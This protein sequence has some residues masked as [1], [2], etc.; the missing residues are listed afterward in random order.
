MYYCYYEGCNYRFHNNSGTISTEN[1]PDYQYCSWSITVGEGFVVSLN[2]ISINIPSCSDGNYINFYDGLDDTAPLIKS[3]CN[4]TSDTGWI[5]TSGNKLFIALKSG[6]SRDVNFNAIY[7]ATTDS[8]PSEEVGSPEAYGVFKWPKTSVGSRSTLA[9]PYNNESSA[10]RECLYAPET[11]VWG[12]IVLNECNYREKRSK[13][14]FLL[15]QK[16]VTSNNVAKIAK[17]MKNLSIANPKMSLHPGDINNIATVLEKIVGVKDKA[18]EILDDFATT[19]DNLLDASEENIIESQSSSRVV[20]ALNNFAETLVIG[21]E[22]KLQKE[23]KNFAMKLKTVETQNF[24]GLE[25]GGVDMKPGE[26][27]LIIPKTIF[28]ESAVTDNSGNQTAIFV[29]YKETKFFRVSSDDTTRKLGRLNSLVLA[30]SIKGLSVKNLRK[31]VKIA[32]KSISR[33]DANSTL[34]S[35][36]NFDLGNWSQD[37]CRF[38]QVLDDGRMLCTCDH[39]TNFAMLMDCNPTTANNRVLSVVSYVGCALSLVGLA[40]TIIMILALKELRNKIP[41]Q[42]L[43]NFCISLSLTLIVFMA[44]VERSKT[45]SLVGC[46]T[47]AIALHY[48]MLAAFA[49]MA[50]EAYNMYLAFVK[51][52]PNSTSSKFILKC[53]L[54]AWGTPAVIVS[55]TMAAALDKYGDETYCRLQGIPFIVALLTPVAFILVGNTITFYFIL[56]SLLKSGKDVTSDLKRRGFQQTRQGIAIMV[57]LGLTWIFGV[58][59]I[60]DAK[61][62][63]QYLFCIFNTL[64][65]LFVFILFCILPDGTRRQIKKFIRAKTTIARRRMQPQPQ[66]PQRENPGVNNMALSTTDLTNTATPVRSTSKSSWSSKNVARYNESKFESVTVEVKVNKIVQTSG[67]SCSKLG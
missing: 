52:F 17:Q 24:N 53:C 47:A 33:G 36:W 30:G 16:N 63:F 39:F 57:L 12:S 4:E 43:L 20:K 31:P 27:S 26:S 14:I 34:C 6:N 67:A 42:I 9:C 54:F 38:E 13:D 18:N 2:S 5:L 21:P 49:W 37:G 64:Q 22:G 61:L 11:S 23:T 50:V 25:Y 60:D 65:G 56:R 8:C 51:V 40:S 3:L 45:S 41:S 48:F 66:N 32:F 29:L 7:Y 10:S 58:L 46:M 44:A 15:V 62:A 35:Y 59:A 19:I 28:K 1:F 55:I